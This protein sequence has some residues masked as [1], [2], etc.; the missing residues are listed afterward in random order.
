VFYSL[1]ATLVGTSSSADALIADAERAIAAGDRQ[2]LDAS[3]QRLFRL[4]PPEEHDKIIGV[5]A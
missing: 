5:T 3:N 4:I 2:A 1:R